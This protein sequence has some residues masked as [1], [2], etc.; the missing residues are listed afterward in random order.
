MP[1]GL[2]SLGAEA[3]RDI[4][5]FIAAGDQKFR[6]VDLRQAYTAEQPPRVPA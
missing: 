2:E 5:T 3:L 6:V 4:L 1:E